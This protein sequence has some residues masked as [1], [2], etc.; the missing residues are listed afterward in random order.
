MI[1][2][3]LKETAKKNIKIATTKKEKENEEKTTSLQ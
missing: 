3:D 1:I 2:F